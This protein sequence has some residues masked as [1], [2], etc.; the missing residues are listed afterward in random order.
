MIWAEMSKLIPEIPD[1]P[2]KIVL[3]SSMGVKDI[4]DLFISG[5]D[6][7]ILDCLIL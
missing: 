4:S 7:K 6:T 3:V 1:N 2:Y 5:A